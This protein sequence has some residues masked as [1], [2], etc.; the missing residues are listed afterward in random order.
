MDPEAAS[1]RRRI[2]IAIVCIVGAG[3]LVGYRLWR[4]KRDNVTPIARKATS[5]I[6]TWRCQACDHAADDYA[7]P[8]PKPCPK[9]GKNE[10][11]AT[12][13]WACPTHGAMP[14]VTQY[15]ENGQPTEIRIG[16]GPWVPAMTEEAG[17]NVFC[18]QCKAKMTPVQPI[19]TR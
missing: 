16:K 2:T 9:C 3:S 18:P 10:F 15:D 17:Y 4:G 19:R 13:Q 1:Q 7:G 5:F 12:L 11:Y 8:G 14:V 6:V